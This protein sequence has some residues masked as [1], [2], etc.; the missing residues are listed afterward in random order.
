MV[1]KEMVLHIYGKKEIV[2]HIYGKKRRRCTIMVKITVVTGSG[3][4]VTYLW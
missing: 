4:G 3:E 1:K 2:L